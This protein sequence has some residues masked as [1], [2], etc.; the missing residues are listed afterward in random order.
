ME[1]YL[2]PLVNV[3]LFPL[4]YKPLNLSE[5][6]YVQMV[7]DSLRTQIPIAVGFVDDA[8]RL[9]PV[10]VGGEISFVS[11]QAGFG[12][13]QIVDQRQNNSL[14]IFLQGAGKVKIGKVISNDPY[15]CFEGEVFQENQN[16]DESLIPYLGKLKKILVGWIN[17]HIHDPLQKDIFIKGIQKPEEIVSNFSAYLIR[18]YD[19]QQQIF[20]IH[21]LNDQIQF[22]EKVV[23][24]NETLF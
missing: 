1:F 20:E 8:Q 2:L 4:T 5:K 7:H 17:K 21:N 9:G 10:K 23:S 18:D 11:A 22:L 14:L 13:P 24:S 12:H 6:K 3:T 16:L 15:I 19:I